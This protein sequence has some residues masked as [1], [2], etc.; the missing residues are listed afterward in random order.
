[1]NNL[2]QIAESTKVTCASLIYG[3]SFNNNYSI[4]KTSLLTTNIDRPCF[5]VV[6][7]ACDLLL[8][9]V[10][11]YRLF[12]F[13]YVCIAVEDSVFSFFALKV[14]FYYLAFQ[15]ARN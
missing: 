13:V 8:M 2:Y 9:D 3:L 10:N 1:V 12:L 11:L 4:F 14:F 7:Y 15:F 5:Y 6:A